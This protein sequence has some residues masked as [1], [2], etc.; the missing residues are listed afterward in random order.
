[1]PTICVLHRA[2]RRLMN[3]GAETGTCI[4]ATEP[5]SVTLSLVST[6]PSPY[7]RPR[8]GWMRSMVPGTAKQDN[9]ASGC[10]EG[11]HTAPFAPLVLCHRSDGSRGLNHHLNRSHPFLSCPSVLHL[12]TENALNIQ[13]AFDQLCHGPYLRNHESPGRRTG[14]GTI[15]VFRPANPAR[16]RQPRRGQSQQCDQDTVI[17]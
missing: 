6:S 17:G 2:C 12:I 9:S 7:L 15:H 11:I 14:R 13:S 4:W 8:S 5:S 3:F 1:M 10:R 16:S